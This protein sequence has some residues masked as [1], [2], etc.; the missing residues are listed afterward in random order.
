MIDLTASLKAILEENTI[1]KVL[2]SIF[3][4]LGRLI[5]CPQGSGGPNDGCL[6]E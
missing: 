1:T 6:E 5:F 4:F 3:S 2:F